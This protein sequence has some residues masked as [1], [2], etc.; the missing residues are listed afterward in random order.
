MIDGDTLDTAQGYRAEQQ[1]NEISL[2]K[3]KE[4]KQQ[5][6][7]NQLIRENRRL[8][9]S[10]SFRIGKLFTRAATKPWLL[11]FL[12]FS[13]L[14]LIFSIGMERLGR[15]PVPVDEKSAAATLQNQPRDSV[16]FFPTNG[17]GFGHF[18][19]M[20]ALAKRFKKYSPS[21]EIVFFTTMPTL[22]LL[23]NEGFVTYHIAGRKKFD[24][25]SAS[26]W[27]AL[28]E[29]HLSL[30]F[31]QHRPST[32][33]FDGA[34]PYRGMLNAIRDQSRVRKI[35]MRRGTFRKGSRI[36]VDSIAHFDTIIHPEDSVP[37]APNEL[38]HGVDSITCAPI[39]LLDEEDLLPRDV[40]RRRL[41]LPL[42]GRVVYVQLGAGRINEIDS[43]I[44]LT[45]EAL[46][47]HDDMTVVVGESMLGERIELSMNRV[48]L[49]RDYPN[50]MYFKAFDATVQAGGYNSFH[51]T[52]KFGLPALFYPNMNTGMDDQLARCRVAEEESW[53]HVVVQR[54]EQSIRE[55][56][57]VL[58][59]MTASEGKKTYG[60]GA[61]ELSQ[62]ILIG[63]SVIP[64]WADVKHSELVHR[65][66][67]RFLE[68]NGYEMDWM[69][70]TTF[71]HYIQ[72]SKFELGEDISDLTDKIKVRDYVAERIGKE[73]LIPLVGTFDS[74][75]DFDFEPD[76]QDI[77]IKTNHGS[78]PNHCEILPSTK[79]KEEIVEKFNQAISSSYYG[80]EWGEFQY[81]N[82][83]PRL[84]VEQRIGGKH[85]SP[86]DLKFHIF[87]TRSSTKWYLQVNSDRSTELKANIFDE[88]Y[89]KIDVIYDG[90]PIGDV[91]LPPLETLDSML[92]IA[93]KLAHGHRYV[94][95]D[96]Y[97]FDDQ[98]FFGELTFTPG[99]G[100]MEFSDFQISKRFGSYYSGGTAS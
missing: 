94:R 56:I 48:V 83:Q 39:V 50:S 27:N 75:E 59:N 10:A 95:V 47:K 73:H 63:D 65:I 97:L 22:H 82:I 24:D 91:E 1:K 37:L 46:L 8:R 45:V 12:P 92:A 33:I 13:I 38:E 36:P 9:N 35:W 79:T 53:G 23:Y 68:E 81:V 34:F 100:F 42:N 93:K 28:V 85:R 71:N 74:I 2:T 51:E 72:L 57:D 61:L 6:R 86:S 89:N 41:N 98:I 60:N 40:A 3:M 84:I 69:N 31:S 52:R 4:K 64:K 7:Q 54:D 49:L 17:V 66:N 67:Q 29:E 30:A 43:E 62:K 99:C 14:F 5:L 76:S 16:I 18:T 15:W 20:Y 11:P 77:V 55:G 90:L 21:T 88:N 96:L 87:N 70:P 19:R 32:F 26:D 80:I 44:R 25:L 78:G 58:L